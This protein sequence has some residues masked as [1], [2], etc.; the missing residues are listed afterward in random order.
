MPLLPYA[1]AALA[2]AMSQET[3]DYHYGRH[4]QTYVDNLNR[5]VKGTLY[6]DMELEEMVCKASGPVFNNAAQ[7][8][9]HTFFFEALTPTP[10]E[11]GSD[12][13]ASLTSRFGSL[14]EFKQQFIAAA[15][16]LFGSGWTWLVENVDGSLDIVNTSGAGNPM[17]EGKRPLLVVDVWDTLTILT[18]ATAAPT[19]LKQSGG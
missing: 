8:W 12:L 5:L 4:L 18:I 3:I 1:H 11:I 19:I 10:K 6:E 17:T 16:S 2:P 7:T 13:G 9:N 15:T 14:G